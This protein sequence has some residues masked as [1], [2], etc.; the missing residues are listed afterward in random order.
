VAY[1]INPEHI[2]GLINNSPGLNPGFPISRLK[3]TPIL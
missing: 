3:T 1:S 2:E